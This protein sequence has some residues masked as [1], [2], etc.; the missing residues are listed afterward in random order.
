M[1]YLPATHELESR[2]DETTLRELADSA[3]GQQFVNMAPIVFVIVGIVARTE[4]EYGAVSELLMNREAGHVAE[5][6]LLQATALDLAAVPVG[7]FDPSAVADTGAGARRRTAVSDADR[8]SGRRNLVR[9][10][11]PSLAQLR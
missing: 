1:H 5:N 11:V 8:A 7:G 3:F 9:E 2:S 6:M 10:W 4:V